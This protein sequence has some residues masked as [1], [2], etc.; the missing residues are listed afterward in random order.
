VV[1]VAGVVGLPAGAG[2]ALFAVGRAAGWIAHVL[3]QRQEPGL[4]RPRARY[5]EPAAPASPPSTSSEISGGQRKRMRGAMP[6]S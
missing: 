6:P 1:A 3:E 4:L 2:A 5:I